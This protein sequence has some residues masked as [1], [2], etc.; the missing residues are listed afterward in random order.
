MAKEKSIDWH[1]LNRRG[2]NMIHRFKFFTI[3]LILLLGIP[4]PGHC[5]EHQIAPLS[6]F[7]EVGNYIK[8]HHHLPD[9]F[10]TK[11]KAKS[12]GW[13]PSRGNL[14]EVAPGKSIGGDIFR[15]FEQKVPE[16]RGRTWFEADINYRG[17]KRGKDR[18]IFSNDGLI[19]KTEDHYRT[20]RN[21]D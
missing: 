2:V 12:M 21:M 7:Q 13:E 20:F 4:S 6:S 10:I 19:Y 9:N 16:K 11:K 1:P 3:F 17:G 15:N 8:K 5:S 18:I 14:W